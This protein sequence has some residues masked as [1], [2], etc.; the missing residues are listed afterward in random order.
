MVVFIR[1][2]LKPLYRP[3]AFFKIT[4]AALYLLLPC[5]VACLGISAPTPMPLLF[6]PVISLMTPTTGRE[7]ITKG[8]YIVASGLIAAVR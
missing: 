6:S 2:W 4:R 8:V 3:I 7:G 1:Y 5:I